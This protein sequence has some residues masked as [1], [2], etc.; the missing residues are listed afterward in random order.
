MNQ[1]TLMGGLTKNIEVSTFGKEKIVKKGTTTL[2]V[3]RVHVKNPES[4]KTDF[5][6]LE[7]FGDR[8]EK[9]QELVGKGCRVLVTGEMRLDVVKTDDT[10]QTY[11]KVIVST[12]KIIDRKKTSE[13]TTTDNSVDEQGFM[14]IPDDLD[15]E[16]PFN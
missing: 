4:Q 5:F 2:A 11:P 15:A 1:I 10:Y 14:T 13:E 16:L 3:D 7:I 12:L 6:V 9:L 8:A